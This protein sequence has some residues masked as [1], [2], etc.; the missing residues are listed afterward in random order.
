MR[1]DITLKGPVIHERLVDQ[2]GFTGSYQQV[3]LY[4][5]LARPEVMA[6][7]GIGLEELDGPHRRFEDSR[8][9]VEQLVALDGER[10]ARPVTR[11]ASMSWTMRVWPRP[12]MSSWS[13]P[14][15][16]AREATRWQLRL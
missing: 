15:A 10:S 13:R 3:K 4:M 6:E 2:Y 12:S 8:V 16:K 11:P 14:A 1:A 7:L 9:Q 5:P